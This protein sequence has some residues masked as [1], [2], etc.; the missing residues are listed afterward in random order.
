MKYLLDPAT[1][2]VLVENRHAQRI[3]DLSQSSGQAAVEISVEAAARLAGAKPVEVKRKDDEDD[4]EYAR[5]RRE[6][7]EARVRKAFEPKSRSSRS[8]SKSSSSKK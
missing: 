7:F 2:D 5:R 4:A 1:G 3:N 6:Q 8:R